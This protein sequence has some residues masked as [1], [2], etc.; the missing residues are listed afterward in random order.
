MTAM[1][2]C[3]KLTK[4]YGVVVG[5]NDLTLEL[6]PGVHGLLGPNGAGKSTLIKLITGQLQ[7]T[8]GSIRVFDQDPWNNPRFLSRIGY[9]PEHDAF[10]TFLLSLPHSIRALQLGLYDV[11]GRVEVLGLQGEMGDVIDNLTSDDSPIRAALWLAGISLLCL[12]LLLR[13]VDAPTRI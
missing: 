13:R 10:W 7:P 5:V 9:C 11:G 3:R 1:L 6:E 2:E 8:A 12:L 4:L